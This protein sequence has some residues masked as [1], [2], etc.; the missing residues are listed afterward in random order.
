[1]PP[2][3][4]Y[5]YLRGLATLEL[6]YMLKKDTPHTIDHK[7]LLAQ[8]ERFANIGTWEVDFLTNK[9][10]WSDQ[11]FRI[12]GLEPRSLSPT[13]EKALELTHPDDAERIRTEFERSRSSGKPFHQEFRIVRPDKSVR[14]V[15]AQGSVERDRDGAP[16]RM[17][18]IF[19][20]LTDRLHEQAPSDDQ[21]CELFE[22]ISKTTHDAVWALEADS[23]QMHLGA[24]FASIFGIEP[25]D[26]GKGGKGTD[27]GSEVAGF[28]QWKHRVHPEDLP[29]VEETL[30]QIRNQNGD[31]KTLEFRFKNAQNEYVWTRSRISVMR[32]EN[33]EPRKIIGAMSDISGDKHQERQQAFMKGF[34]SMFNS[35]D[36]VNTMLSKT[37][38]KI[39]DHESF[40]LG[41]A[42]LVSPDEGSIKLT[43]THTE[44]DNYSVFQKETS[45]YR[46]LSPGEDL[47]G[48]V[49][50]QGDQVVI[51]DVAQDTRFIRGMAAARLGV[52]KACGIPIK[53][54]E[55]IIGVLVLGIEEAQLFTQEDLDMYE[56]AGRTLGGEIK[57]R[58]I[59]EELTNLFDFSPDIICM[60][61]LDGAIKRVNPA[62]IELLG[63]TAE[64]LSGTRLADLVHPDDS[65]LFRSRMRG[66]GEKRPTSYQESRFITKA[67]H[68]I[69]LGATCTLSPG[70][71]LI[72]LIGRDITDRKS[73]EATVEQANRLARIGAWEIDLIRM[74]TW[75]SDIARDIFEAPESFEP[76]VHKMISLFRRGT[77]RGRFRMC[78]DTAIGE[79]KS[80]DEELEIDTARGNR[81]WLR[82]LGEVEVA[83]GKPVRIYGSLQDINERKVAELSYQIA[84]DEKES[85][86]DSISDAFYALDAHWQFTYFNRKSEQL[87]DRRQHEVI[88]K[89]IWDV[90]PKLR[91]TELYN[92]YYE[93]IRTGEPDYFEFYYTVL[94][95][96]YE[97]S[98]YPSKGR[99]GL[100]IY[101]KL[102][103]E[104]KRNEYR[105]QE[106][107]TQMELRAR[108]LAISNAELEQFATVT[109]HDLQEPLR[110]ITG[111]LSQLERKYS[112]LLDEKGKRYIYFASDGAKRMRKIIL[113]LLNFSRVGNSQLEKFSTDLNDVVQEI[114]AHNRR[115]IEETGARLQID[116]MPTVPT[117]RALIRQ[118]FQ[119]LIENAIKYRKNGDS[120]VIRLSAAELPKYWEFRITDNGIGIA[121][122]FHEKI[123]SI[124]Q[125]LHDNSEYAG[126]GMGLAIVKKI[127]ETHE[128]E[129]R[130]ESSEGAGSTFIFTL[131]K[132]LAG[133]AEPA[134]AMLNS[135]EANEPSMQ[136]TSTG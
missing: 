64:E 111:F 31:V 56:E 55:Q 75:W 72:Y 42:W 7:R 26:K 47:P 36:S 13:P 68:V 57:R 69:W 45:R 6:S 49:W 114:L 78:I 32:D 116:V 51:E 109:S 25:N 80:W 44:D 94:E 96:W 83:D 21:S 46:Q 105:L 28:D 38:E 22:Q 100:T 136:R 119:H 101:Y 127:V 34:A 74:E 16:V 135:A 10:W 85:I 112:H 29:D 73:L 19:M 89:S 92:K 121:P 104:R 123:F 15:V 77:S 67:G 8:A 93:V 126:T 59:E 12:C 86:L 9:S 30:R 118:V 79:G 37:L 62:G 35:N 98:V 39:H 84:S 65:Y 5:A 91:H 41:E 1:M 48:T 124:F 81:C 120:P 61:D 14:S 11:Y 130:V 125:R 43:E 70:E 106:L 133:S 129:I 117:V 122:E 134:F 88:G 103:T 99:E 4:A 90:F 71:G 50:E 76:T 97:M 60:I 24:G 95:E 52:K 20:D 27:G 3:N 2:L 23:G 132:T 87:L 131:G 115:L 102:I 33:G 82:V 113:D 128:G 53:H 63:H 107:N 40:I 18:G 110:M 58:K 66:M 54:N 108:E 17:N